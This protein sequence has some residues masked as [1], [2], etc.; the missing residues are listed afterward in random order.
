MIRLGRSAWNFRKL[1][2]DD[3]QELIK[4]ASL[5]L[6]KL[7]SGFARST[8]RNFTG[9]SR[10]FRGV[11]YLMTNKSTLSVDA[12]TGPSKVFWALTSWS[13]GQDVV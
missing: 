9:L 1:R 7:K 12:F 11:G 13:I 3:A 10:T 2:G 6:V 4:E 5:V 8:P